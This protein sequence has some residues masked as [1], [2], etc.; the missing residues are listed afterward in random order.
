MAKNKLSGLMAKASAGMDMPSPVR[1]TKEEAAERRRY[2]AE[3]DLR[4]VTRAEEIRRDRE[5]MS[6]VRKLAQE[7]VKNLQCVTKRPGAK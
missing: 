7:Q 1:A 4:T 5:R 2:R 6:D 3:E